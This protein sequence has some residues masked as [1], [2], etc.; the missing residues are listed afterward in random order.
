MGAEIKEAFGGCGGDVLAEEREDDGEEA[1]EVGLDG[2]A[3]R[4]GWTWW[5][6]WWC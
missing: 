2:G 1:E 5:W 3:W 6:W 4:W